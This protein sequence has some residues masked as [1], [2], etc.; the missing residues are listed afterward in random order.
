MKMVLIAADDDGA[1]PFT[2]VGGCEFTLMQGEDGTIMIETGQG[3][4]ANVTIADVVQSNGV[5][6]VI[7][8]V[9]LPAM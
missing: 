5:I 8:S 4:I 6:H 3:R 2:T 1:H 9:L 7:D